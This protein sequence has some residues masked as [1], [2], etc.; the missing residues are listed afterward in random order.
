MTWNH[1][2]IREN[3]ANSEK[4]SMALKSDTTTHQGE[5]RTPQSTA[6][7]NADLNNEIKVCSS[8]GKLA[9]RYKDIEDT[10]LVQYFFLH[11]RFYSQ[12]FQEHQ[13]VNH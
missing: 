3:S 1:Q 5:L 13:Y 9:K 12:H 2:Q 8:I 7:S 4:L 6:V 10:Y 11:A